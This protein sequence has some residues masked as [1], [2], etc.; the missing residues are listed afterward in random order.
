MSLEADR[1]LRRLNLSA[2]LK[3]TRI[4]LSPWFCKPAGQE[5]QLT[6]ELLP[7]DGQLAPEA[8][9]GVSRT[10]NQAASL[11]G[12]WVSP[13]ADLTFKCRY[14]AADANAMVPIPADGKIFR[15]ARFFCIFPHFDYQS[16]A[17]HF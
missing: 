8:M 13:Q 12:H 7:L 9:T 10:T 17:S 15:Y 5:G 3:D 2:N 16:I 6:V 1:Q 14:R 4:G 11:S